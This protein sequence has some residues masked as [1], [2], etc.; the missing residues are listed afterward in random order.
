MMNIS[1]Y[2][3][4]LDGGLKYSCMFFF[5]FAKVPSLSFFE[6]HLTVHMHH[7]D[8]RDPCAV[9]TVLSVR[10]L[11]L[12]RKSVTIYAENLIL[13]VGRYRTP[14]IY[15]EYIY[16]PETNSGKRYLQYSMYTWC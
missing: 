12:C 2:L 7:P 9:F 1:V 5:F 8:L 6:P 16:N 3:A 15:A 13:D 11:C 10:E 4:S 14:C